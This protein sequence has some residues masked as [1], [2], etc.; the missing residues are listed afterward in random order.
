MK[1]LE[2]TYNTAEAEGS[3][4][5]DAA[6]AHSVTESAVEEFYARAVPPEKLLSK[7]I[8]KYALS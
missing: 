2:D 7:K 3:S 6:A 4:G 8:S 1:V 5:A